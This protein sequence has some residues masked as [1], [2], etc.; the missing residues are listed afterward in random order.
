MKLP[1]PGESTLESA[2]Q[3]LQICK[4][5]LTKLKPKAYKLRRKE[6]IERLK[7]HMKAGDD[8]AAEELRQI[9]TREAQV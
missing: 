7:G 8:E 1:T 9:I 3:L 4:D 2:K 5:K 6:N